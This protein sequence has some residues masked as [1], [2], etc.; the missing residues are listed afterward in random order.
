MPTP[1]DNLI[2]NL[3]VVR[4]L[5]ADD[6]AVIRSGLRRIIE[7]DAQ[8]LI[9]AEA[10]DGIVALRLG[11]QLRP[12]VILMDITMPGLNGIEATRSLFSGGSNAK[13][14]ALS[15]HSDEEMMSQALGAG[16]SG[17]VL[18]NQAA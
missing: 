6:H 16:A 10:E 15:L 17:Y 1:V 18:K 3:P 14:L 13:V 9:V 8:L 4:I 2:E 7:Q 11:L 12:D 5:L